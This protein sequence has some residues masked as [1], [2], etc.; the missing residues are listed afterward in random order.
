MSRIQH[1][2][3][4]VHEMVAIYSNNVGPQMPNIGTWN[5]LYDHYFV[6]GDSFVIVFAALYPHKRIQ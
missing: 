4:T 3:F 5:G 1:K 6:E 2:M